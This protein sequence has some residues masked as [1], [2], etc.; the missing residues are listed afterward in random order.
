MQIAF[1]EEAVDQVPK[2]PP[3]LYE[4]IS[5][6]VER[7]LSQDPSIPDDR[8][9]SSAGNRELN[10][11]SFGEVDE[12]LSFACSGLPCITEHSAHDSPTFD[13]P[14][15]GDSD[16]QSDLLWRTQPPP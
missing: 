5:Q 16:D 4:W 11:G 10:R 3:V 6:V 1:E 15:F 8:H 14:D 7:L 12:L 2:A 13:M 9:V